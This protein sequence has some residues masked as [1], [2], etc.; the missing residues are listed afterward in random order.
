M[1][2]D[3]LKKKRVTSEPNRKVILKVDQNF[4]EN[5]S[6]NEGN[7]KENRNPSV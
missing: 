4:T 6:T 1:W 3:F 7:Q 2:S 5:N